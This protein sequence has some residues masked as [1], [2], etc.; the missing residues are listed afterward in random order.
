[1]N[2]NVT[3]LTQHQIANQIPHW[4]ETEITGNIFFFSI[5]VSVTGG[6]KKSDMSHFDK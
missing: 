2:G 3:N 4:C 5:Y 6:E 1:M